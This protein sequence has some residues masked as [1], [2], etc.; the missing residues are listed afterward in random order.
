MFTTLRTQAVVKPSVASLRPPGVSGAPSGIVRSGSSRQEADQLAA[1]GAAGAAQL[2]RPLAEEICLLLRHYPAHAEIVG[3]DRPVHLVTERE[4]ALLDPE[5]V[6]RLRA[7]RRDAE[8]LSGLHGAVPEVAHMA[9]RHVDL[10]GQLAGEADPDDPR[11]QPRD[12]TVPEGHE[13]E[14]IGR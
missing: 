13:G 1:H 4:K 14:G 6:V 12:S 9:G 5:D 2:H 7:D 11:G 8:R 3:V 10:E